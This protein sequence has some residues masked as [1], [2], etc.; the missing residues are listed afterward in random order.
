MVQL[1]YFHEIKKPFSLSLK[2]K[3]IP[4]KEKGKLKH[5]GPFL[6]SI[7]SVLAISSISFTNEKLFREVN[8]DL[9]IESF[10]Y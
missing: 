7:T 5:C 6:K 9:R 4:M 10:R 1:L 3:R 8:T 2:L